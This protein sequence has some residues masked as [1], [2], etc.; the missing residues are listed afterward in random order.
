MLSYSKKQN[1]K[2]N[3]NEQK[4]CLFLV[5]DID[6]IFEQD[7]GF[8]M[9]L[10]QL[11][12]T[13][14]RP[15]IL[16]TSNL[17]CCHLQRFNHYPILNFRKLSANSQ[18]IWLQIMCAMEG[19]QVNLKCIIELLEWNN[20]DL[21]KTMLHL[22]FWLK[23]GGNHISFN[24]PKETNIVFNNIEIDDDLEFTCNLKDRK[25]NEIKQEKLHGQCMKAFFP[26]RNLIPHTT[27]LENYWEHMRKSIFE[28]SQ[29]DK[30]EERD[31]N[32]QNYVNLLDTLCLSDLMQK[33]CYLSNNF[34]QIH[35]NKL[36]D[37]LNLTECLE[38]YEDSFSF[39]EDFRNY[40]LENTWRN[41]TDKQIPW[42]MKRYKII[43]TF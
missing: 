31:F 16:T 18:A 32:L 21:R 1:E 29:S 10:S 11:L 5:D 8:I 4:L 20:G 43:Y 35:G 2:S 13:S 27:D 14:K 6:I 15:I 9:A 38:Y 3:C 30:V 37:S 28:S 41:S 23:S 34:T 12:Q 22:Q 39:N 26:I 40:L 17:D 19:L 36:T 7:E 25:R 33:K 42:Y 24:C